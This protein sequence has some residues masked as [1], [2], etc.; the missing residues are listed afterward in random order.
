MVG[1]FGGN[2][3]QK[4]TFNLFQIDSSLLQGAFNAKLAQN[5]ASSL[6]VTRTGAQNGNFG[7]DVVPP[8]DKPAS[9]L[10]LPDQLGEHLS[11]KN[12]FAGTADGLRSDLDKTSQTL[13]QLWKGLKRMQALTVFAA[14]DKRA[15]L[16][17]GQLQSQFQRYESEIFDF[18][19]SAQLSGVDVIAGPVETKMETDARIPRSSATYEGRRLFGGVADPIDGLDTNTSFNINIVKVD[20]STFD[21]PIDLADVGATKT[22]GNISQH[23]NDQLEAA[24][25][26]TRVY[27]Y[28]DAEGRYGLK[29]SRS[30]LEEVTLSPVNSDPAVYVSGTSGNGEFAKGSV[31]KFTDFDTG[32]TQAFDAKTEVEDGVSE[33]TASA[34]GPNGELFTL[35]TTTGDI[36]GQVVG[37][38]QDVFLTRYDAAGN[39]VWRRL[40]GATDNA[41]GYGLAVAD[42]GSIAISGRANKPLTDGSPDNGVNSFVT[43][44]DSSGEAQ[45]TRNTGPLA[46]DAAFAVDFDAD[47]NVVVAGATAGAMPGETHQGGQDAYLQKLSVSNGSVLDQTQFGDAG[48]E[49]ATAVK[50]DNGVVYVAGDDDGQGF[51]RTYDVNDLAGGPTGTIMVGDAAASTRIADIEVDG[52]G[53][54]YVAG[55]TSDPTFT[56]AGSSGRLTHAGGADGFVARLDEAT[57]TMDF[58]AYLGTAGTDRIRD[59]ALT[60]T[61]EIYVTGETDGDLDGNSLVGSRDGFVTRMDANG[62]PVTTKTYSGINGRVDSNS[63]VV[64]EGGDS[65][66]TRLGLGHGNIGDIGSLTVTSNS[67]VRPGMSFSMAV[68]DGPLRRITIEADDSIRWVAFQMNRVLGANGLVEVKR[69]GDAEYLRI[70]AKKDAKI[71]IRSGR[72][73]F[74]ALPGLGLKEGDIYGP[75]MKKR[76]DVFALGFGGFVNVLDFEAASDARDHLGFALSQIEK[77]F[78]SLTEENKDPLEKRRQ[79]ALLDRPPAQIQKQI[80]N[81]QAALTRLTA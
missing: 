1:I 36:G 23:I 18:V 51:V 33:I 10:D 39:E 7:P 68:D 44:Y 15:D 30:I 56:G 75:D 62:A 19:N 49:V 74:D 66:L 48:T 73:G 22:L 63:I 25:V 61:G 8:W 28:G 2:N 29:V 77:A 21:I 12:L 47:G 45:W 53:K 81:F 46:V 20:G 79:K 42:D 70:N 31:R 40:V 54:I 32:V 9:L 60:S 78:K 35:G 6:N 80:A 59:M 3:D 34:L 76:D 27:T 24:G 38:Q 69:E 52:A 37:G 64:D 67:A 55:D 58:G 43:L 71:A 41:E 26:T 50:V 17:R 4:Q 11:Q 65:A 5:A 57:G 16:A 72:D 13:F 14:E